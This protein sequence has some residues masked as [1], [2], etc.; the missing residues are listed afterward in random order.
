LLGVFSW[1]KIYFSFPSYEPEA[2][3]ADKTA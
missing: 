3:N 1:L 2:E